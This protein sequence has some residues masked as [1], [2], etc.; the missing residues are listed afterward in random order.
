MYSIIG[1]SPYHVGVGH[2]E[3]GGITTNCKGEWNSGSDS[4]GGVSWN[5]QEGGKGQYYH[6]WAGSILGVRHRM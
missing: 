2:S 1:A 3:R 6:S 5:C 4:K